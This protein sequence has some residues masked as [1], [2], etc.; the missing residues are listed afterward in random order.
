MTT[1]TDSGRSGLAYLL[2]TD[3]P[4]DVFWTR[5]A[6][7]LPVTFDDDE[8]S[9][10]LSRV[11]KT[12]VYRVQ[13]SPVLSTEAEQIAHRK[14]REGV[15]MLLTSIIQMGGIEPGSKLDVTIR[16]SMGALAPFLTQ[17]ACD[18]G[19]LVNVR[20]LAARYVVASGKQEDLTR[21]LR[22]SPST[23]VRI[24][25]VLGL[26]DAGDWEGV[27]QFLRDPSPAVVTEAQFLLDDALDG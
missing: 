3:V 8:T 18:E 21:T 17:V 14:I 13:T 9:R 6:P 16:S 24:G 26:A 25:V 22:D 19:V 10:A 2:G 20:A 12:R 4:S 5:R 1:Q 11:H 23:L 15:V 27:N 7:F